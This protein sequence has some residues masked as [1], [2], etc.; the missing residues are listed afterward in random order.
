MMGAVAALRM[1]P[2]DAWMN[3]VFP[4]SR[5]LLPAMDI[6]QVC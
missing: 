5:Q 1:A 6:E 4:A 2:D 3:A